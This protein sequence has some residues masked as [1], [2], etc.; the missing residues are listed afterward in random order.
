MDPGI[1]RYFRWILDSDGFFFRYY[2][3]GNPAERIQSFNFDGLQP[4]CIIICF[5]NNRNP[6]E[7]PINENID[8]FIFYLRGE[9]KLKCWIQ[10]RFR[11]KSP[12]S[13]IGELFSVLAH[14][15]RRSWRLLW[16]FFSCL[17][18]DY[19]F[20]NWMGAATTCIVWKV[21][22]SW[23]DPLRRNYNPILHLD[24]AYSQITFEKQISL[25]YQN[26]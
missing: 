3:N 7:E 11:W 25:V 16:E 26:D 23:R 2:K 18:G 10:I 9:N 22:Y 6:S 14:R 15:W 21:S 5:R 4:K 8:G 13:G 20:F 17:N 24:Q 19:N 1:H 12:Q